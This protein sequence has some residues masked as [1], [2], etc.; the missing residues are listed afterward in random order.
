M[1]SSELAA[2]GIRLAYSFYMPKTFSHTTSYNLRSITNNSCV[3]KSV[4]KI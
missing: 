4:F 3:S 2:L 1:L